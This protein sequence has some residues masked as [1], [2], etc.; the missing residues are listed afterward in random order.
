MAVEHG[1]WPADGPRRFESQGYDLRKLFLSGPTLWLIARNL[2]IAQE[3]WRRSSTPA[4]Q[5]TRLSRG[6]IT[7]I[8]RATGTVEPVLAVDVGSFVSGP[9]EAL[10][11]DFNDRVTKGQLIAKIDPRIYEGDVARDEARLATQKADVK[12]VDAT[13]QQARNEEQRGS[14]VRAD[15]PAFISDK[16]LD[17][18]KFTRISLEAQLEFAAP[19]SIKPKLN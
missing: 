19:M 18:L 14:A 12:R 7:S 13:L 5:T 6:D 2:T 8:V 17:N 3:R 9:I 10:Y 1:R 15:N 16:E 4:F 11:A